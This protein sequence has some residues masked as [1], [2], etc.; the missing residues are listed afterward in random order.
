MNT[1]WQ[2]LAA[3]FCFLFGLALIAN[4]LTAADGEWYWYAWYLQQGKRLYADMQLVD[5]ASICPGD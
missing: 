5:A 3:A 1:Y 4:T 2:R